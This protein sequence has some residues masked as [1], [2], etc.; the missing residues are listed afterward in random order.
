LA[1]VAGS[2]EDLAAKH[3]KMFC[4]GRFICPLEDKMSIPAIWNINSITLQ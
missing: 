1:G 2:L 3:K 4:C